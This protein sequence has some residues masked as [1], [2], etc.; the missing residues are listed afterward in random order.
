[1]H[2]AVNDEPKNVSC[3]QVKQQN[4]QPISLPT[5]HQPRCSIN[6]DPRNLM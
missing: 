4:N 6:D 3:I 2:A 5:M 1:M